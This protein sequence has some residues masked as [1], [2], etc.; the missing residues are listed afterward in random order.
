[1]VPPLRSGFD[2]WLPE[3]FVEPGDQEAREEMDSRFEKPRRAAPPPNTATP[4]SPATNARREI[5][6]PPFVLCGG[7]GVFLAT[8]VGTG[9]TEGD[10]KGSR[11]GAEGEDK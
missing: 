7:G 8:G 1:M 4:T 9:V 3:L 5:E 2:A 6:E 10:H 11:R